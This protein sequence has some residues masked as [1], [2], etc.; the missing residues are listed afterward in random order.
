VSESFEIEYICFTAWVVL[1]A[2]GM[3]ITYTVSYPW[4]RSLLGRL[5]VAYALADSAMATLLCVAVV[6]RTGPSWFRWA[7]FGLQA[8]LGT[9]FL[10]QALAIGRLREERRAKERAEVGR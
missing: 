6:T 9:T 4:W 1:T 5:V 8:V 2:V 7:W 3:V 10:V